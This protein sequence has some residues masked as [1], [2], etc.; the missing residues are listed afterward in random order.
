MPVPRAWAVRPRVECPR[1]GDVRAM[2]PCVECPPSGWGARSR[3]DGR[4]CPRILLVWRRKAAK[5]AAV[6]NW[7]R[8]P[9]IR[10]GAQH[11]FM[12]PVGAWGF[13]RKAFA[14]AGTNPHGQHLWFCS[15]QAAGLGIDLGFAVLADLLRY[16][17]SMLSGHSY[18]LDPHRI[19]CRSR[20]PLA[21]WRQPLAPGTPRASRR[22]TS[23]LGLRDAARRAALWRLLRLELSPH[24]AP[25]PPAAHRTPPPRPSVTDSFPFVTGLRQMDAQPPAQIRRS[26]D[27]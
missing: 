15:R 8:D 18:A 16:L 24:A 3:A 7:I 4:F 13:P 1:T 17:Q 2:R 20:L 21:P 12:S 9:R 19:V 5:P 26:V 23:R 14:A 27:F 11:R 10:T 25:R 22:R 6:R